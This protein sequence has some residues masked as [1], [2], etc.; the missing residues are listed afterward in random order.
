MQA[1]CLM[2]K[3]SGLSGNHREIEDEGIVDDSGVVR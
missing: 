1:R 3:T 2:G